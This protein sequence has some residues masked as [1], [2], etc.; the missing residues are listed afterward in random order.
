M[1]FL[2][3]CVGGL[4]AVSERRSERDRWSHDACGA[5]SRA[6]GGNVICLT[7]SHE[8]TESGAWA[9]GGRFSIGS[10]QDGS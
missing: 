7:Q 1:G 9:S 2:S 5:V 10:A 4:V 6:G 8:A 3:E